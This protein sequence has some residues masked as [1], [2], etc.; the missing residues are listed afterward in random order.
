MKTQYKLKSKNETPFE[1]KYNK[2]QLGS[3]LAS[4]TLGLVCFAIAI[5]LKS[6][7]FLIFSISYLLLTVVVLIDT[8]M[9]RF[10]V[11]ENCIK[12]HR[13]IGK[14][15]T[16]YFSDI[17]TLDVYKDRKNKDTS[18]VINAYDKEWVSFDIALVTNVNKLLDLT[19]AN[20]K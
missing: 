17:K 1:M 19:V 4:L 5:Y 20:Y 16:I 14:D 9:T 2:I 15:K 13:F 8:V 12:W 18:I 11:E 10:Y 3:G 7:F 6:E